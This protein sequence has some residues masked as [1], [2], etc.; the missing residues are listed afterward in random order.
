MGFRVSSAV[1]VVCG[2][3]LPLAAFRAS[4]W[5]GV[6]AV[7]AAS[8]FALG[9]CVGLV[10]LAL[11]P[12]LTKQAVYRCLAVAMAEFVAVPI[13]GHV[14]SMVF[15][16]QVKQKLPEYARIVEALRAERARGHR[17]AALQNPHADIVWAD[18]ARLP[19]GTELPRLAFRQSPRSLRLWWSPNGA[20]LGVR[21]DA[22]RCRKALSVDWYWYASC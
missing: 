4:C 14:G 16:A 20:H 11:R 1:V 12:R 7:V 15:E 6:G 18:L 17:R 10:F 8:V 19:D 2:A 13:A 21:D 3:G 5:G 9:L 22:G